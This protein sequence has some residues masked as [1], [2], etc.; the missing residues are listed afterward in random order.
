[1]AIQTNT[2]DKVS[3]FIGM[4][5]IAFLLVAFGSVAC[6]KAEQGDTG[7]EGTGIQEGIMPFEGIVKAVVGKYVFLPEA[8]GFDIVIQGNLESGD[9]QSLIDKQVRGEGDISIDTPSILVANTLEVKGD[10]GDWTNVFTRTQEVDLE[11]FLD[12][13]DREEFVVPAGLSYDKKDMWEE[14]ERLKVYGTLERND[15]GDKIVVFGEEDEEIGRILVDSYTDFCQF[16]LEKLGNFDKFWFYLI[17]K[18]TV[19]W[20]QRRRTREMFHA[21]VVFAGL[22]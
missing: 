5:L 10:N 19:D 9:V 4:M 15:N 2:K 16:Y 1:M 22:F 6:Q 8:S 17:V 13:N 11:D 18:E 3:R 12:L 14:A 21:D 7:E 20:S